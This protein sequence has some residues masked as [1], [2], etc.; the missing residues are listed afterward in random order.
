MEERKIADFDAAMEALLEK[1][2]TIDQIAESRSRR[3]DG[4]LTLAVMKNRLIVIRVEKDDRHEVAHLHVDYNNKIHAAS[5]AIHDGALIVGTRN[6]KYDYAIRSWIVDH[7]G[8][9]MSV[10]HDLK[11][12]RSEVRYVERLKK[13]SLF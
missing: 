10:W 1:L 12:S 13:T 11:H 3:D 4:N 5:Y 2:A 8:K 6:P 9:L 7:R